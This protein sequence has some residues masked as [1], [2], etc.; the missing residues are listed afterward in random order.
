MHGKT[1][2]YTHT[3]ARAIIK[4]V[5]VGIVFSITKPTRGCTF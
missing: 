4:A 5:V 1:L 2:M 3:H